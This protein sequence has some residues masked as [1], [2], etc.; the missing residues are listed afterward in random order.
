MKDGHVHTAFCPHGTD[1][2]IDEY[3]QRA[4]QLGYSEIT[5][6]EHAPLPEG[7][8][9]PTPIQDSAMAIEDLD[10]YFQTIAEAKK[11]YTGKIKI[12]TGFEIDFIQGYENDTTDFLNK[13]GPL[14]DDG[15]LSVHFLKNK[16]GTYDCLDYSPD[17]FGKMAKDYGSVENVH[18]QYYQ[19]VMKSILADLGPY[20]PK[21]IGHMTLANKFRLKYPLSNECTGEII[22]ILDKVSE[23]GYELDY[24]G[25]GTAKPLCRNPYPPDW[26]IGEAKKRGIPLVYGSDA[27][28]VKEL[29]QGL[30]YMKIKK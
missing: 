30:E 23:L 28:Q 7:F 13:Y 5:F 17:H 8:M 2:T 4:L 3:I 21:R 11:R 1:D 15:V 25:A 24:N 19:T 26:V 27:H 9:D 29:G 20:K 14:L 18:R 16:S 12:N 22:E 6:A 10:S